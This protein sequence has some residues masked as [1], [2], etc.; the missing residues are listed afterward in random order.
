MRPHRLDAGLRW[1]AAAAALFAVGGLML[2]PTSHAALPG[3]TEATAPG[4]AVSVGVVRVL[5]EAQDGM[6]DEADRAAASVG[7]VVSVQR[8]LGTL[9]ADVSSDAVALC[10]GAPLCAP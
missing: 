4:P 8:A 5:V 2:A 6:L 3:T 7:R 1:R 9:V 10:V